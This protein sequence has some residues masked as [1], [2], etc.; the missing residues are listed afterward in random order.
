MNW[1]DIAFM[2]F[3]AESE[4][5]MNDYISKVAHELKGNCST[6][7]SREEFEAACHRVGVNPSRFTQ[8]DLDKM[9]KILNK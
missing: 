2:G 3:M 4:D 1:E 5:K 6:I 8:H 7:I 9:V